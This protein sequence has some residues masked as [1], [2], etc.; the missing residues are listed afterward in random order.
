MPEISLF[1]GTNKIVI[2][3]IFN[4]ILKF[5]SLFFKRKKAYL[6]ENEW[7]IIDYE[8]K[9]KLSGSQQKLKLYLLIEI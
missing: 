1:R 5:L 8:C 7:N 6:D 3:I 4:G 2:V 9:P